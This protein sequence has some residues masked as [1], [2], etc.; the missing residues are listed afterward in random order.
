MQR[1]PALLLLPLLVATACTAP[2]GNETAT[3]A[4]PDPAAVRQAIEAV[5]AQFTASLKAGDIEALVSHYDAEAM[6]LPPNMPAARGAAGIREAFSGMLSAMTI[7]EFTLT[8][9]EVHVAGNMAIET[10]A[11]AMTSQPPQGGGPA[12]PDTGKFVVVWRQQADGSWKLFRD[13][14]NSDLPLPAGA[15]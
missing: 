12:T 3:A 11:Y 8:T 15:H 13:I 6:V 5:N 1:G 9:H 14:F 2:A 7:T 4:A 10:G